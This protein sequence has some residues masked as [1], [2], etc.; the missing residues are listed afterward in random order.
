MLTGIL[1]PTSGEVRVAGIVPWRDRKQNARNIGVIFGQRSQLYWDLPLIESFELL[2]AIYGVPRNEYR[3]KPRRVRRDP[4]HE[5][6]SQNSGSP[7]LARPT[8]ARRFRRSAAPQP[9]DRL[10]RRADHRTRRRGQGSD[11]RV[12]RADQRR[13][14]RND[15]ADD[16]RPRGRRA[17]L[18]PD[19]ADRPRNHH[20]RR[21]HRAHQG[22]VRPLP[23]ARRPLL[24]AGFRAAP[25]R[26]RSSPASRTRPRGF[27]STA[28][29][30]APICS[31]G[32]PAN[33]TGVE[34]VSF[35][36]PDLESIIRR[37]YVEGYGRGPEEDAS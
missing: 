16:A 2:R 4:R 11:S 22:R 32:K 3:T 7:A 5:R 18:P 14:R 1:V 8:H 33:V 31:S 28:T 12:H 6:L 27:G 23:D 36:E 24:R 15:P 35:E 13:A 20:L 17:S 9:E 34:D 21:R 30:S 26:R 19:R 10:S 37:I 25:R 29:W